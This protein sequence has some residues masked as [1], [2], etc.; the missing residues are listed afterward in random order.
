MERFAT[1]IY[2][3]AVIAVENNVLSIGRLM[4]PADITAAMQ[5]RSEKEK[6][7]IK[8]WHVCGEIHPEM[9][10]LVYGR[11]ELLKTRL[12]IMSPTDGNGCAYA[13][14]FEE[15]DDWQHRFVIPLAGP[16]VRGFVD[17]LKS[18]TI[19][20]SLANRANDHTIV[21]SLVIPDAARKDIQ[22]SFQHDWQ[23]P[24]G[25]LQ[26][27]SMLSLRLMLPQFVEPIAAP[28]INWAC[29]T[30]VVPEDIRALS[31]RMERRYMC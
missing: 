17:A 5:A 11:H 22:A 19:S 4:S 18:E 21:R 31:K 16:S 13:F 26:D 14:I 6:E 2:S 1:E 23:D 27:A 12:Q 29:V 3:A 10:K 15:I 24:V 8:G 9:W 7:V 25:Q 20:I 28:A 30:L